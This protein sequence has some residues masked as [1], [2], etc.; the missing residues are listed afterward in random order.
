IA[1]HMVLGFIAPNIEWKVYF[2]QLIDNLT[3]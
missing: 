2:K 1:T 3:K